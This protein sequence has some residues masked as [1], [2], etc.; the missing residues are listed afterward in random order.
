MGLQLQDEHGSTA[1]AATKDAFLGGA[2][3]AL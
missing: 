1:A 3:L 2:V